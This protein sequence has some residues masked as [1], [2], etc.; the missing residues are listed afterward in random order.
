MI[1]IFSREILEKYNEVFLMEKKNILM[2]KK[3]ILAIDKGGEK[4]LY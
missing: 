3:N 2:E 4:G 1:P